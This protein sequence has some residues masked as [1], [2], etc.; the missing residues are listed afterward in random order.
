MESVQK[1]TGAVAMACADNNKL[2][3]IAARRDGTVMM[4]SGQTESG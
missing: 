3:R 1:L 2:G 4:E